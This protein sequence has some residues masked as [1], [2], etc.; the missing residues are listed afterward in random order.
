MPTNVFAEIRTLT[1]F[2]LHVWREAVIIGSA[3]LFLVLNQYH[4]LGE[5]W[6][7]S[8]LFFL[9]LPLL[10][11]VLAL[12]RNPLDFGWRLGD[13]RFW[14]PH[15]TGFSVLAV[16]I[17]F[18]MAR[19]ASLEGYYTV[20]DF[21]LP[22]YA[23][24]QCG[25]F[26]GWEFLYRGFLLFGLKEKLGEVS[27]LVQVIPFVLMHLN[28]PEVETISTIPIGLYWGYVAYRGGSCWPAIIMH[29]V[30]NVTFRTFVNGL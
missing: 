9:C 17:L 13:W 5:R 2:I 12:R 8:L 18:A 28:K 29:L 20:E 10:V 26:L 6:S 3:S 30:I 24:E 4:T 1:A 14:L 21:S 16:P 25:Y 22:R 27:I 7:D 19:V 11:I 15:A 23:L